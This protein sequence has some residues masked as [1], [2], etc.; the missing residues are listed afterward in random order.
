VTRTTGFRL[1]LSGLFILAGSAGCSSGG[2]PSHHERSHI[3]GV[4]LQLPR[5][6][7]KAPLVQ[8][9]NLLVLG[10]SEGQTFA[11]N[12][13]AAVH[14]TIIDAAA[15]GKADRLISVTSP[16]FNGP[17]QIAG[18]GID[19]PHNQ[20]VLLN[21]GGRPLVVMTG[22]TEQVRGGEWIPLTI[23][24]KRAGSTTITVQIVTHRG[25]YPS[26]PPAP[27]TTGP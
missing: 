12:A 6:I 17:T 11:P 9:R 7:R 2:Q 1:A 14:A 27:T 20:P 15:D 13:T 4:N 23:G 25:E 3:R 21:A 8:I 16:K 24:F 10:P 22:L 18:G 26:L 19:L 5:D